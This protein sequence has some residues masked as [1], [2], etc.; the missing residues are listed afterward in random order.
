MTIT[1]SLTDLTKTVNE[2][3][4]ELDIT[5]ASLDDKVTQVQNNQSIVDGYVI[6]SD[7]NVLT[8]QS[9]RSLVATALNTVN[10]NV[11]YSQ[12]NGIVES[13]IVDAVDIFIYDTSK[14]SDGGEWRKRCHEKSW[15]NEP[16]NTATRGSRREFPAVAVIVLEQGKLTVYDADDPTLPMWREMVGVQRLYDTSLSD[17]WWIGSTSAKTVFSLDGKLCAGQGSQNS[18]SYG[19]GLF[20]FDFVAD[21]VEQRWRSYGGNTG[22]ASPNLSTFIGG[23][24]FEHKLPAIVGEGIYDVAMTVLPDAPVD[25]DTGLSVPTIAVATNLGVSVIKDDGSIANSA[26]NNTTLKVFFNDDGLFYT[27]G[28]DFLYFARND[29]LF[30]P[31]ID[32]TGRIVAGVTD[33]DLLTQASQISVTKKGISVGGT[34]YQ[35]DAKP[36]L[37]QYTFNGSDFSDRLSSITSY[38]YTSGWMHGDIKGAFLSDTNTSSLVGGG[39]LVTNGGFDTDTVWTLING[40]I[41]GGEYIGPASGAQGVKQNITMPLGTNAYEVTFDAYVES[42]VSTVYLRLGDDVS[43]VG[44]WT[45][46]TTPTNYSM[47]ANAR[48]TNDA[49][50]LIAGNAINLHLDNISVKLADA[51]RSVNNNGLIVNGTITR[52]PVATGA[53]LVGYEFGGD[54]ANYLLLE[55]GDSINPGAGDFCFLCWYYNTGIGSTQ[56]LFEAETTSGSFFLARNSSSAPI[57]NLYGS[58]NNSSIAGSVSND[59]NTPENTWLNIAMVRRSGALYL[60]IN[61]IEKSVDLTAGGD[62][63]GLIERVRIGNRTALDRAFYGKLALLR[64]TNTAPTADQIMKIYNDERNLFQEN[65]ACTLYGTSDAV[66]ALAYDS[67]TD[68]LHV[69]T[70]SGRSVFDGLLRVSNTTTPITTAISVSDGMIVEQ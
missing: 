56:Y 29:N 31:L 59:E 21:K 68:L 70:S 28:S 48:G 6:D 2:T 55:N 51:D 64:F 42:S 35:N 22:Y 40:S 57:V 16:L 11:T 36:G 20:V 41:I 17:A 15:Y 7:A 10:S 49:I 61:G 14:D 32:E 37:S 39:E 33:Y 13:K 69:G 34:Q 9:N 38:N 18:P 54:N 50:T 62:M 63:T 8:A 58:I 26:W 44:S 30:Y 1:S 24:R 60:Y 43:N 19:G 65:A 53:E 52:S 27:R 23:K 5:E 46:G 67:D 3:V 25:P 47:T 45:I 12:I 66:T 4:K